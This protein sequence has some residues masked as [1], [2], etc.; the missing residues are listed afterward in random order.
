MSKI[1][2]H[3]WLLCLVTSFCIR[4]VLTELA[5]RSQPA[6]KLA[7]AKIRAGTTCWTNLRMP[8]VIHSDVVY[9]FRIIVVFNNKK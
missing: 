7:I 4:E 3:G 1:Y 6:S 5:L 2:R 8:V 9:I